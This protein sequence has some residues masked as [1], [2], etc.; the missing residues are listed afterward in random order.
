MH[1]G[2]LL[3]TKSDAILLPTTATYSDAMKIL[4]ERV[5][6]RAAIRAPSKSTRFFCRIA[7]EVQGTDVL[8]DE[9]SWRAARTLLKNRDGVQLLFSFAF[10]PRKDKTLAGGGICMRFIRWLHDESDRNSPCL[11]E[12]S[13][14][15]VEEAS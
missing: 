10:A 9:Q 12:T 1:A 3:L 2:R 4:H 5:L 13:F 14:E 15:V 7:I 11:L 6:A 8:M